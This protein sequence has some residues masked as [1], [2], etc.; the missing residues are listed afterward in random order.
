MVHL[1]QPADTEDGDFIVQLD[2][3]VDIVTDHDD[4]LVQR[5]LHLKKCVLDRFA[6]DRIDCI[7][8]LIHQQHWRSCRQ[9][10]D[11]TDARLLSARHFA[12]IAT[13]SLFEIFF[14][15]FSIQY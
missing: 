7:E 5:A 8:R 12:W 14:N 3:F 6:V 4:G 2:L 1:H 13:Q 15:T 10:T 9:R 11:H